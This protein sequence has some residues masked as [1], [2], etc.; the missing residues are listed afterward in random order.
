METRA[1]KISTHQES[2]ALVDDA[3]RE[4]VRKR[5][6]D[7]R[8]YQFRMAFA[9]TQAKGSFK[10]M[11]D[12]VADALEVDFVLPESAVKPGLKIPAVMYSIFG[13]G[14]RFRGQRCSWYPRSLPPTRV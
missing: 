7:G 13:P 12:D 5:L 8:F 2:L 14:R 11:E 3:K 10:T 9:G 1:T 4:I 6:P